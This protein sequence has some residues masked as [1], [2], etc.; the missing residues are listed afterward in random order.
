MPKEGERGKLLNIFNR[1]YL[2]GRM[3][4][5]E[6]KGKKLGKIYFFFFKTAKKSAKNGEE[7][8]KFSR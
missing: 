6:G 2:K 4:E 1:E 8:Q 3:K 5:K 7:F